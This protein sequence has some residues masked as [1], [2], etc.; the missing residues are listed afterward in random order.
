MDESQAKMSTTTKPSVR[1]R[2]ASNEEKKQNKR[3][4][5]VLLFTTISFDLCTT[6]IIKKLFWRRKSKCNKHIL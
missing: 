4:Q 6:T 3:T 1:S 5:K 2:P